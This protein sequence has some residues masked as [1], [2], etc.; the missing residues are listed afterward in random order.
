MKGPVVVHK[1]FP[2]FWTL[3]TVLVVS[4]LML[5]AAQTTG[6]AAPAA[7]A[8]PAAAPADPNAVVLKLGDTTFT[9]AQFEPRFNIALRTLAAQ[10]G[11][12]LDAATLA[13]FG[14]LRP[15]FLDQ[16]AT[17]QVLLQ[18]AEKRGLSVPET[19]VDAQLA[20][21]TRLY[22]GVA[23]VATRGRGASGHHSGNP[24]GGSRIL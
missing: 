16:F 1:R 6:D 17:Q 24:S 2:A 10:Q 4:G 22:S 11:A 12:P 18:D 13:Q 3:L 23:D 5:V 21:A 7:P 20:Q 8:A 14:T 9:A 15:N 19:E